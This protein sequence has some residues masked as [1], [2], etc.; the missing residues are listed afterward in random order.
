M[1]ETVAELAEHRPLRV[2]LGDPA[3]ELDGVA[4]ASTFA[5]VPGYQE[6]AAR[7]DIVASHPYP[8]L[9]RPTGGD[10]RSHS[11]WIRRTTARR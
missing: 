2:L 8:W 10:V 7:L 11:V 5:P 4:L 6:R 9:A 3:R 1:A